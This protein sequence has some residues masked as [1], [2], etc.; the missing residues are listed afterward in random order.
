MKDDSQR[1]ESEDIEQN[2][3]EISE[4]STKL[5]EE[6]R[7]KIENGNWIQKLQISSSQ[8][9]KIKKTEIVHYNNK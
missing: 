5:Y 8:G 6:R 4:N 9:K 7:G 1:R 2:K 3:Q